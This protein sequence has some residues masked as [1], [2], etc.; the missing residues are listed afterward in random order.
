M[1]LHRKLEEQHIYNHGSQVCDDKIRSE[2]NIIW[3][4]FVR[5]P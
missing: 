5:V 2:T 3:S 4:E 1:K